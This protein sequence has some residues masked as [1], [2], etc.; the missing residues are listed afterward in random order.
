ML[1][2]LSDEL[3]GAFAESALWKWPETR[4]RAKPQSIA[5]T[6]KIG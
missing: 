1:S 6:V 4:S 2:F 5:V 3:G